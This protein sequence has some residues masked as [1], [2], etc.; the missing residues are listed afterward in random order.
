MLGLYSVFRAVDIFIRLIEWAIVI[1]CV[2]SWIR[3]AFRAFYLLRQFIQPFIAPFQKLSLR[4]MRRF[5]APIDL[6][7]FFA[8]IG[9]QVLDRLWWWLY[10]ILA[11]RIF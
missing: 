8:V 10:R 11:V 7:C 9:M 5:N 4:L 6:T 3:P 2:L 1:Y